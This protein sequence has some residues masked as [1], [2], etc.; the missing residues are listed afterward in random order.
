MHVI[1]NTAL[2]EEMRTFF[3]KQLLCPSSLLFPLDKVICSLGYGN[4][5]GK[6][7]YCLVMNHF[8]FI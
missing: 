8:L 7:V 5:L 3:V 6:N 2:H 4:K 1:G